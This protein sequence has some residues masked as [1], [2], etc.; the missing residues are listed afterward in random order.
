MQHITGIDYDEE[1]IATANHC[2]LRTEHIRFHATDAMEFPF[3][4]YDTIILADMLHYLQPE[5][6]KILIEKC[7]RHT[8]EDGI[9]IIRD[10]NKDLEERHKGTRLTE[11]FST[12]LIGFNKTSGKSLSFLSGDFIRELTLANGFECR[13]IDNTKFTSN[14]VFV[15]KN[16]QGKDA[17]AAG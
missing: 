3:Q 2:Y 7:F 17:G 1:K 16:A 12:K 10:G 8:T 15:L 14:I 11:F 9:V 4:H 6:Q 5:Q 13:E